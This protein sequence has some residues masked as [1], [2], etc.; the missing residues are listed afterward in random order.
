[1]RQ[2]R[3]TASN[4]GSVNNTNSYS[5]PND[6]L[7]QILWPQSFDSVAM[8]YGSLNQALN[9]PKTQKI[10][11]ERLYATRKWLWRGFRNT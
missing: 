11:V 6:L 1:M 10:A 9:G 2:R 4:F 8:R 5:G 7:R 3:V